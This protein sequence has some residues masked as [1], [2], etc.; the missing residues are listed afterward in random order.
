MVQALALEL[1]ST[2]R[3]A[4]APNL[5]HSSFVS[6]AISRSQSGSVSLRRPTQAQGVMV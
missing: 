1:R 6:A 4:T 5:A 3:W 2:W